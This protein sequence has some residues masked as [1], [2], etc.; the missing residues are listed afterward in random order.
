MGSRRPNLFLV[1]APRCGTSALY[2][3][4]GE[5]PEVHMSPVKELHYFSPDIYQAAPRVVIRDEAHYLS[6]FA[7]ATHERWVGEASPFYLYARHAAESIKAF[8]PDARIIITLRN[9]ADMMYSMYCLRRHASVFH[10]GQEPLPTFE[11]ALAAGPARLR[12]EQ[13]PPGVPREPGRALYLCY[14]EL[15]RYADR[16]E[17]YLDVFGR[18]AVHVMIFDDFVAD[19]AAAYRGVC[20]FLGIDASFTPDFALSPDRRAASARPRSRMLARLLWRP[21]PQVTQPLRR[22]TTQRARRSLRT[23]L[24]RWN[25]ARPEP[26]DPALRPRILEDC[27]ADV[28]RLGTLIGREL[29]SW[30]PEDGAP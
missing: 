10:A 7:G 24:E 16:V 23:L 28:R 3:H 30:L 15:G 20:E 14:A 21:P 11:Q 22:V 2:A 19:P 25:S 13:L 1:G 4:L 29:T 17:R 8:S 9:P 27:A 6:M 18:E 26:L 5:H 12:G